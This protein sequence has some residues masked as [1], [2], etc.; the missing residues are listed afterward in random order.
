MN[1][2]EARVVDDETLFGEGESVEGAPQRILPLVAGLIVLGVAIAAI[3][4]VITSFLVGGAVT[5]GGA[6]ATEQLSIER[7]ESIT[8][9]DLPEGTTVLDGE[10]TDEPGTL[11]TTSTVELPVGAENPLA[12]SAYSESDDIP[13]EFIDRAN[14]FA[15]PHFYLAIG[16]AGIYT[17][18]VGTADASGRLTIDFTSTE[19]QQ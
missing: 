9:V 12:A 17:A 7:I 15:D 13:D 1:T 4:I 19:P 5:S 16:D 14:S 10:V 18:L 11:S 6:A 8:Q 3:G 2:T